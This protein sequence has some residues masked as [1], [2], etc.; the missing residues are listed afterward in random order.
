MSGEELHSYLDE[1]ERI[2]GL[3]S[4]VPWGWLPPL[5]AVDLPFF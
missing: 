1:I 3:Y 5:H 4:P 2:H